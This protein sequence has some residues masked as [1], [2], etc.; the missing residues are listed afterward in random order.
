[1]SHDF[2]DMKHVM[3]HWLLIPKNDIIDLFVML[4]KMHIQPISDEG[5]KVW[6]IFPVLSRENDAVHTNSFG[7]QIE[8]R[9]GIIVK[10]A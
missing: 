9:N 5:R 3:E 10:P 1:M 7:L 6:V 2:I 8:S 4:H